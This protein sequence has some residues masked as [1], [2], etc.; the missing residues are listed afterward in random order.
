MEKQNKYKKQN[1]WHI[2]TEISGNAGIAEQNAA[3]L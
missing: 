3:Q 2:G 1:K